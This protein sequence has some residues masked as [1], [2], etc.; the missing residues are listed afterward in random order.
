MLHA[1]MRNFFAYFMKL[2]LGSIDKYLALQYIIQYMLQFN[3]FS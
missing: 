2:F 1:T 3:Y